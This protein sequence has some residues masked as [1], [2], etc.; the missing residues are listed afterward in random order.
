MN[1]EFDLFETRMNMIGDVVDVFVLHEA[2]VTNDG[3]SKE[4]L[5][6][7]R[8][9]KG[10]LKEHHHKF[11]YILQT[12][13]PER[14]IQEG[15]IADA[16]MRCHM[17][18]TAFNE[19]LKGFNDDDLWISTDNDELLR[20]EELIFLKLYEGYPEPI[21]FEL[22]WSVF[23]FF[24]E[25]D[26]PSLRP[27]GFTVRFFRDFYQYDAAHINTD[28]FK[29]NTSMVK[30]YKSKGR[31]VKPWTISEG[32]GWHCS[33]CFEPEGILKKLRDAPRSD[34]PRWGDR[35]NVA[36]ITNIR[37]LI[38]QGLYF[39]EKP[40]RKHRQRQANVSAPEYIQQNPLRFKY[41]LEVPNEATEVRLSPGETDLT[42][43]T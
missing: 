4:P 34:Y 32:S 8:F 5:F 15:D 41:L 11:V 3:R 9:Q 12:D 39:D 36:N 21:V 28:S 31:K 40:I 14:G 29:N 2:S 22:R 27:G 7:K 35:P 6:F 16:Y 18:Q 26:E 38:A 20:R 33:W 43:Q 10:W 23:G 25:K 24:W 1:H 30:H 19:R 17:S 37:R 42:R 13:I